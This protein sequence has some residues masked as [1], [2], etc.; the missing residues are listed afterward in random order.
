MLIGN[1]AFL[2]EEQILC[3][4]IAP[5][6]CVALLQHKENLLISPLRVFVLELE[7]QTNKIVLI[8]VHLRV[9]H[10]TK[11]CLNTLIDAIISIEILAAV[12]LL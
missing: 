6:S 10:L 3:Y 9:E 5:C 12:D 2:E 7:Q 8:Q 4:Y 1:S 11:N